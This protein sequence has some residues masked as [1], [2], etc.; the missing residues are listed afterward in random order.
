MLDANIVRCLAEAG[1][2]WS[3]DASRPPLPA[4]PPRVEHPVT[5]VSAF[6]T[7]EGPLHAID[8]LSD[9]GFETCWSTWS[10]PLPQSVTID[11]GGVWSGVS[12]LDPKQWNRTGSTDGDITAYTVHTSTDGVSFTQVASGGRPGDR[13]LKTARSTGWSRGTAA[14]WPTSGAGPRT[15][16]RSSSGRGPARPARREAPPGAHRRRHGRR[17]ASWGVARH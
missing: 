13:T 4:Q 6:H 8:G 5:P 12:S 1:A 7:G 16:R 11:L 17:T 3:P 15:A 14:R 9:R 10:L 2:A